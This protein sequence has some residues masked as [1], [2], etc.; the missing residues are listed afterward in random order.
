MLGPLASDG[1]GGLWLAITN[2]AGPKPPLLH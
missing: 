1:H 2:P